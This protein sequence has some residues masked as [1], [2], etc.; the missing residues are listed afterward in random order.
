M[1]YLDSVRL[2][3]TISLI[4]RRNDMTDISKTG[5]KKILMDRDGMDDIEA[6]DLLETTQ[7]EVAEVR[8]YGGSLMEIED[9]ISD[10]LGLEPDFIDAFT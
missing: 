1:V 7:N 6:D 2:V 8:S 5:I 4:V 3:K 10:N 9:I